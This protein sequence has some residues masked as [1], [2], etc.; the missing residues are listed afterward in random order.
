M[1]GGVEIRARDTADPLGAFYQNVT[2]WNFDLMWYAYLQSEGCEFPVSVG[3]VDS[4]R[5][6]RG[7]TL[8]SAAGVG[9]TASCLRHR[10]GHRDG[11]HFEPLQEFARFRW[12]RRGLPQG[13][14]TSTRRSWSPG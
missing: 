5:S 11:G 12:K 4:L 13:R 2:S 3:I 10:V 14:S 8:T 7:S 6:G 1:R 9:T